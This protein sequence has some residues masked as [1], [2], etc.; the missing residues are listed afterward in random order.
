M[1]YPKM[2][3]AKEKSESERREDEDEDQLKYSQYLDTFPQKKKG[4]K[5]EKNIEEEEQK[6]LHKRAPRRREISLFISTFPPYSHL[7]P[8]FS[9]QSTPPI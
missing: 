5:R 6:P 8:S 2:Y 3:F 7:T 4:R 1:Q 9:T